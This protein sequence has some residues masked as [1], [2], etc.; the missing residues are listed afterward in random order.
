MTLYPQ[1]NMMN[2]FSLVIEKDM[3]NVKSS[4]TSGTTPNYWKA[5]RGDG[6]RIADRF[7]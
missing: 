5:V 2:Y 7:V 3:A 6:I 1:A 4:A